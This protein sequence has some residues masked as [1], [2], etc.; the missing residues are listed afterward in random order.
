MKQQQQ[1][2][3]EELS[4]NFTGDFKEDIT[5]IVNEVKEHFKELEKDEALRK[6]IEKVLLEAYPE[7]S[8]PIQQLWMDL[9]TGSDDAFI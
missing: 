9:T 4:R 6:H 7:E 5:Y 8:A 2:L 1:S 3:L